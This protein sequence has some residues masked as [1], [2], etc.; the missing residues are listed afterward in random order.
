MNSILRV[1]FL[2]VIFGI[3]FGFSTAS[4]A[5]V[6]H[7]IA[8]QFALSTFESEVL[9]TALVASC[10]VGAAVAGVMSAWLGR[11]MVLL[12]AVALAGAGYA[13]I[14]ANPTHVWLLAARVAIGLSVGLSS[15]VAPMYAAEAV[16]ARHR[17][18]VVSLFQL[19]VTAGILIAYVVPLVFAPTEA[20]Q[21]Q[22]G[23]GIVIAALGLGAILLVPESPRWLLTKGMAEAAKKSAQNLGILGELE[24]A[25]DTGPSSDR[26]LFDVLRAGSTFAVLGFC[27]L[28]FILQNLSGI[29]GILYYAPKIFEE[30][31]FAPGTAALAAT[32]GLGAVNLAATAI[33]IGIVDRSGRR[34]LLIAGSAGMIVGLGC[35]VA[36]GWVQSPGL[37]LAGL[38][39]YIAA[40]AVSLG[41]LP[42]VFMAELFPTA[43]REQGIATA[44][45]ISWLFNALVALT[46]LSALELFGLALTFVGFMGICVVSLI[47]TLAVA[48]ETR[49]A[50]LE[51]IEADILAGR[52]L[53]V[54]AA[55]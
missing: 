32:V 55:E 44:S 7:A 4:I 27:S 24:A 40:F 26:P 20:W 16:V 22:L 42:Y 29:D 18:A 30:L 49:G 1:S 34:P 43:I 6:L 53:R 15:M 17:G 28:L 9:V 10:F 33:A 12:I 31:G 41:P 39:I 37:G 38:C 5:G 48:P 13:I 21:P 3:L 54:I 25:A 45:A 23:G 35:V 11:R 14:L 36:A 50:S 19:A 51:R 8:D 2:I 47:V 46:F 52:R